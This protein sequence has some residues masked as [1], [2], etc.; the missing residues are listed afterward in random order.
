MGAAEAVYLAVQLFSEMKS[1]LAIET[2][3][4]QQSHPANDTLNSSD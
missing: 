4:L 2:P 1:S 3:T